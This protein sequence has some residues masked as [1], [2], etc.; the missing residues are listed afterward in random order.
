MTGAHQ[1]STESA[2]MR[3]R[4]QVIELLTNSHAGDRLPGERELAHRIGVARMTLRRAI[5]SLI[6]DIK[7]FLYYLFEIELN[8]INNL[9]NL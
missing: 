8:Y 3:A 6:I 5:E 1:E 2:V 9:R 7:E 4:D